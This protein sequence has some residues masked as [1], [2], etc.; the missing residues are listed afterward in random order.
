MPAAADGLAYLA[1]S[2]FSL[3]NVGGSSSTTVHYHK[4]F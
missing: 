3:F 4:D 2:V 1:D